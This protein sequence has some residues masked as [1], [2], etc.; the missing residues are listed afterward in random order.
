MKSHSTFEGTQDKR[1]RVDIRRP[2][3][4]ARL[5]IL[6]AIW[7][8]FWFTAIAGDARAGDSDSV[9]TSEVDTILSNFHRASGG[10]APW[11]AH[12]TITIESE[13]HIE[14]M[15]IRGTSTIVI[16]KDG[17]F[18]SHTEIPQMLETEQGFDGKKTWSKDPINGLRYVTG[19]EAAALH[20]DMAWNAP[21]NF[22]N[23]FSHIELDEK[24]SQGN[25]KCLTMTLGK[26]LPA[27]WC[28]DGKTFL[29]R[30]TTGTRP[31]PQGE[32]PFSIAYSDYRL[33][34]GIRFAGRQTATLGP[35]TIVSDI[36]RITWDKKYPKSRFSLPVHKSPTPEKRRERSSKP[37]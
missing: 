12:Q 10:T 36:K 22:R 21:G 1:S 20:A 11:D 33:E 5:S 24:D 27:R 16:T 19:D 18:Y 35:V 26:S 34:K 30:S 15:G 32:T 3:R 25:A 8:A 9:H 2:R 4:V 31:S 14:S 7:S 28:F 17:R 37:D 13:L 29:P 6:S 23:H